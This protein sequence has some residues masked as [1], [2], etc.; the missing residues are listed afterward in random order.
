MAFINATG[1]V[2]FGTNERDIITGRPEMDIILARAGDDEIFRFP[3]GPG[4]GGG[5]DIID[6]G[7]GD[8]G[9]EFFVA[10]DE[11]ND[12]ILGGRGEDDLFGGPGND[13][14]VGEEGN[15]LITG[16]S[17]DDVLFGSEGNDEIFG[18]PGRD[19]ITGGPGDD[20][21]SGGVYPFGT[22]DGE[23]DVFQFNFG[24]GFGLP[25]EPSQN[26]GEARVFARVSDEI[27]GFEP[28]LDGIRVSGLAENLD[29]NGDGRLDD[30]DARVDAGG[31]ALIIDFNGVPLV[32]GATATGILAVIGVTSLE[33]PRDILFLNGDMAKFSQPGPVTFGTNESDTITGWPGKDIIL[34][35]SGND[36]VFARGGDDIVDAG[37][38]DDVVAGGKGNDVILGGEGNDSLFGQAGDD[39]I[40]GEEGNDA[41][42]GSRGDDV[43]F[44]SEGNDEIFGGPGKDTLTGGPDSDLLTGAGR[45]APGRGGV[46]DGEA[47][48]FQFNFGSGFGLPGEPSQG[49]DVIEAFE[50]GIDGIRVSG[51]AESLDSNG[52]GRL[53]N[54]DARVDATSAGSLFVIDFNGVPLVDGGTAAG[55]LTLIG[56]SGVT[57]LEIPTDILFV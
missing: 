32:D 49:N 13:V 8:D 26:S 55:T 15:E 40:V 57:S 39:V 18:G 46:F 31:G 30:D 5:D 25:G 47:D 19:T 50:P 44:G 56:G 12:V 42:L 23:A 36:S 52:D 54:D 10:G 28:G 38:G 53:D 37:D 48:V 41:I 29:S 45:L 1:L 4:A 2:T 7:D 16:D 3:S 17:G 33:V 43:L 14:I 21:L 27:R 35:R 11:G 24:P 22:S 20:A 9:R 34:A 51:L 6:A